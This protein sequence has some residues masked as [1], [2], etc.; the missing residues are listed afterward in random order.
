MK[1]LTLCASLLILLSCSLAPAQSPLDSTANIKLDIVDLPTSPLVTARLS[2]QNNSLVIAGEVHKRN[3]TMLNGYVA[4]H[5][6]AP[7]G[8]ELWSKRA[9]LSPG[10]L[11][12][13]HYRIFEEHGPSLP[14]AGSTVIVEF[15]KL[16]ETISA[17]IFKGD[18]IQLTL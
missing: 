11:R 16:D 2:Q 13:F 12:F 3:T 9:E 14:P 6:I 5:I 4:I 10:G 1:K 18:P 7:D 15:Q 8:H 17:V